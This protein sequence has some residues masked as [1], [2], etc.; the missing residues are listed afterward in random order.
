[1]SS[2]FRGTR[3][4]D[5]E[6]GFPGFISKRR[7]VRVHVTEDVYGDSD[8][9]LHLVKE[10]DNLDYEILGSL[11]Y[12]SGSYAPSLS[13][14]EINV[15]P[16]HDSTIQHALSSVE[17]EQKQSDAAKP[18]KNMKSAKDGM[19][20]NVCLEQVNVGEIVR[21]LPC[22]HQFHAICIDPWL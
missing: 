4:G 3:E 13:E 5:I 9:N 17:P 16:M 10:F 1:M 2:V 21:S 6:S 14:E 15:L 22:F 8:F 7:Q 18:D 20:C 12:G 11:D 19:T